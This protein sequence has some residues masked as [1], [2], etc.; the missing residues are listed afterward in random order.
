MY[1]FLLLKIHKPNLHILSAL[2][3]TNH[4][5]SK[6]FIPVQKNNQNTIQNTF[7]FVQN[8]IESLHTNYSVLASFYVTNLLSIIPI[9]ETIYIVMNS[10]F[11]KTYYQDS[12]TCILISWK[13]PLG[14][15]L[16]GKPQIKGI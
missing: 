9:Y 16:S 6:Y 4:D 7:T 12:V 3:T 8:L 14:I 10:S 1:I 13:Y 2:R 5:V 15:F 11:N